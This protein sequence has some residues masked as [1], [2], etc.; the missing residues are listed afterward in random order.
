MNQSIGKKFPDLEMADH[1][2]QVVKLS[3]CAGK[4]PVIISFYRG[5]W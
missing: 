5:Y 3:Q 1:D 4:F 2:N